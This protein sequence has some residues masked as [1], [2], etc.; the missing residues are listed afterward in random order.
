MKL[1]KVNSPG[2]AEII[3]NHTDYN[4]GYA[5]SCAIT[6]STVVN[7][8]QRPDN[9]IIAKSLNP[10]FPE[11]VSFSLDKI[12]RDE[13]IKWGN[14]I[15]GVVSEMLKAG[16]KIRGAE[17]TVKTNFSASGGLS[18]S[19]AFE[20]GVAYGLL[21]LAGEKIEPE[22]V[23]KLCQKAEN[24]ELVQSPCGFLDQATIAFAQKGKMVFLDFLPPV[25]VKLIKA[26]LPGASFVVAVDRKVKRILG[27]SG[28]PARRKSCEKA[29]KIL[30][31]SSLREVDPERFEK[32]KSK[33]DPVTRKRAE[34]IVYE[35][36][37]VLEAVKVLKAGKVERFGELLSESGRSALELYDLAEKTPELR[38]L[39]ETAQKL[40][41]V[42]GARNMGGGF[43][44][45]I[46]ALVRDRVELEFEKELDRKYYNKYRRH[47]EFIKFTPSDG[48]RIA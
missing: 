39:M 43:S 26:K 7:L 21:K 17:I 46:L 14:Y 42:L 6:Q 41:G 1:V 10:E 45:I 30:K 9:Q 47:L 19:A 13:K 4:N 27:E 28:Y 33:L 32:E 48:V 12:R 20:L 24:G 35:N 5:L 8:K 3:G 31:I 22:A 18:S 36:Q 29:A 15:R 16:K 37:R 38:F 23:A 11:K 2:R 34:H 44:A 25:K 40:N